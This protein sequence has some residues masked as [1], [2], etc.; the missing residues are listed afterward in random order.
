MKLNPKVAAGKVDGISSTSLILI[1]VVNLAILEIMVLHHTILPTLFHKLWTGLE[2]KKDIK[3]NMSIKQSCNTYQLRMKVN[4]MLWDYLSI[5]LEILLNHSTVLPRL[6]NNTPREIEVEITSHY[7]RRAVLTISM[8]SGTQPSMDILPV[9][10]YLSLIQT[11]TKL[12]Q[13]WKLSLQNIQ[14]HPLTI[15]TPT[16]WNGLLMH[17]KLDLTMPGLESQRNKLFLKAILQRLNPLQK[18]KLFLEDID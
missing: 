3:T 2:T 8:H 17:T 18:D 7:P 15:K 14:S 16:T 6:T 11:G 9:S 10:L 5:S 13:M 4:L 12:K 1:R